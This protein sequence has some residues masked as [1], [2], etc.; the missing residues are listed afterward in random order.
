MN[1]ALSKVKQVFAIFESE[2]QELIAE[3]GTVQSFEADSQI[4]EVGQTLTHFPLVLTGALKVFK[5]SQRGDELLLYY[6]ESGD[7]CA[8]SLK[9]CSGSAASQISAVTEL[10]SEFILI[11]TQFM[12]EWMTKFP[13]WRSY[14]LNIFND[15]FEELLGAVD[16]LA[17]QNLERRLKDFL[18][19]KA[20]IQRNSEIRLT[21]SEIASEL[22]TSRVVI[23]RIMKKLELSSFL[24]QSRN[25]IILNPDLQ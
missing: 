18:N 4:M 24:V 23:S 19:D 25:Q 17:F 1:T 10:D 16:S 15:R 21:H 9:C 3:H 2:L 8:M 6:L 22:N 12:E 11:P 5:E 20:L 13:T 14:V 7:S